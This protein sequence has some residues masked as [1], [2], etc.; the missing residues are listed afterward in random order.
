MAARAEMLIFVKNAAADESHDSFE[1]AARFQIP[2]PLAGALLHLAP[3]T[4]ASSNDLR[5][6]ITRS[7]FL[8]RQPKH[9]VVPT[10]VL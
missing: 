5:L 9:Y 4:S 10:T 2:A 7:S 8:N 6:V 1:R 3:R